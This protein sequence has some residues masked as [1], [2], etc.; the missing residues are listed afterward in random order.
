VAKA[1]RP[2]T[3]KGKAAAKHR[4]ASREEYQKLPDSKKKARVSSRSKEA[5]RKADSKR[6]STQRSKRNAYHKADARA[7]R[8]IPKGTKCAKCGSTTNIQRHVV[9]GK[10]KEYLCGKCNSRAIGGK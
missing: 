6:L 10:F 7:T 2:V 3:K 1:G 8:S 5:Q 4:K 9:N